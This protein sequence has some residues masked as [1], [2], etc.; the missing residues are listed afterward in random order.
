V[1]IYEDAYS[2]KNVIIKDN[3]DKSGIYM[4]TNKL[5]GDIYIGSSGNI[6]NRLKK[7]FTISYLKSKNGF[8]I[9]RALL[10]YGY[11]NFSLTVLEYC[12]KYDLLKREQFYLDK[13]NPQYNILKIAGSSKNFKHSE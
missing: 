7:Y 10:K 13:L 6:S 5:T 8:I 11:S 12:N 4:W 9:S 1:Y 2:M 3:K